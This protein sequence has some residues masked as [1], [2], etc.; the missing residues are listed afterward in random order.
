MKIEIYSK[1][2]CAYCKAAIQ[3]AESR[4][5]EPTVRKLDVDFTREELLAEFPGAR[6]FPQIK[7]NDINIGG[8]VELSGLLNSI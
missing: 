7:V 3:L 2:N 5:Y 6:M 4:G 8:F 1:D